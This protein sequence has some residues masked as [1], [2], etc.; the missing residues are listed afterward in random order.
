LGPVIRFFGAVTE[1][2][3]ESKDL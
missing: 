3:A 1:S 2:D